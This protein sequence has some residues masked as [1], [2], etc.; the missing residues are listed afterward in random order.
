MIL[1]MESKRSYDDVYQK[2]A[3]ISVREITIFV[4]DRFIEL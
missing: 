4:T 3:H 1:I 2:V